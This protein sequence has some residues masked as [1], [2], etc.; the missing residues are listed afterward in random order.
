VNGVQPYCEISKVGIHPITAL[1]LARY[2]RAMLF[3]VRPAIAAIALLSIT[4]TGFGAAG[5]AFASA[6]GGLASVNHSGSGHILR[7]SLGTQ[8]SL[9]SASIALLSRVHSV[10][11]SRPT[12]VKIIQNTAQHTVAIVF[13]GSQGG[14]PVTGL[15]IA[16]APPGASA[17][18]TVIYDTTA[19]FPKTAGPLLNDLGSAPSAAGGSAQKSIAMAPAEPLVAHPF[20]DNTGTIGLPSDWTLKASGGGSAYAQGPSR[21]L[22]NY[23]QPQLAA[24]PTY[25]MG[26]MLATGT[27]FYANPVRHSQGIQSIALIP[28]T[29]DPVQAWTKA[30]DQMSMQT[31]GKHGT[32]FI[33]DSVKTIA[34][35]SDFIAGHATISSGPLAGQVTYFAYVTVLPKDNQGNYM[36]VRSYCIVPK[37]EVAAQGATAA[38][39]FNSVRLNESQINANLHAFDEVM[40]KQFESSIARDQEQDALREGETQSSIANA[41]AS[42]DAWQAQGAGMVN[43][44]L[45]RAVVTNPSTGGHELISNVS[46]GIPPNYQIVPPGSYIKGVDY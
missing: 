43:F 5:A 20:P 26:K 27:G 16:T 32:K 28:Y 6:S 25:G 7:G 11:G 35:H 39:V 17:S 46:S 4:S 8:S 38:A 1:D 30:F 12:V 22:V 40:D 14:Q 19:N 23:Q 24:D 36:I 15:S 13:T 31:T 45:D 44:A 9:K 21:E 37:N 2:P 42:A 10:L 29:G 33:V 3:H 34:A 18:G 41:T